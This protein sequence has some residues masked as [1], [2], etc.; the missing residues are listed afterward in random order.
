MREF[1]CS[2]AKHIL[3]HGNVIVEFASDN[4][5]RSKIQPIEFLFVHNVWEGLSFANR[6]EVVRDKG[7]A[8]FC[9]ENNFT[10]WC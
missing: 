3:V 10:I 4:S 9:L 2:F 7:C 6:L 1:S 5:D 8:W